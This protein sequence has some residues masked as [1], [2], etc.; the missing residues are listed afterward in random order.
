MILTVKEQPAVKCRLLLSI[1]N[2]L[3]RVL[4]QRLCQPHFR[5]CS[6]RHWALTQSSAA[7]KA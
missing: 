2:S 3:T 5:L 7:L 4:Q 1:C 6:A